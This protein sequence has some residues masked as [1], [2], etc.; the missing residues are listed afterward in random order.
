MLRHSLVR[1]VVV[2]ASA[3]GCGALLIAQSPQGLDPAM[4][5]KPPVDSWPTYHGDYS[6]RRHST[7]TQI[8]PD[9]VH[10][11]TVAWTFQT[12][13]GAGIK[14]RHHTMLSPR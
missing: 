1:S 6:G 13:A 11:L 3:A 10:Q 8:T 12:G 9:N 2:L 4:M 5:L 14:R 7:L